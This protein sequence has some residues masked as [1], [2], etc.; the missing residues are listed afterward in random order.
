MKNFIFISP[1][2]PDVYYKFL[3]E[4]RNVGFNVL[5]IGDCPWHELSDNVK[6]NTSEYYYVHSLSNI[7]EMEEAVRYFKNKYGEIDYLES[8]NEFWL[9]QDAYLREKFNVLNGLR[10]ADMDV[11]KYKS[12]MKENF[13]KAGVKVARYIIPTNYEETI[14]FINSVGYPVFV[15]PDNGVGALDSYAIH[16]L[17]E[18][19]AFFARSD[20]HLFIMEE[21]IDGEIISFDGISDDDG[22]VLINFKEV[23]PVPI[24]DIANKDLDDLYYAS[25]DVDEEFREIGRKV[26]KAFNIKKRCFHIEFFKLKSHKEGLA[27]LGEIIALEVNMRP[28]GGNTPDLLSV[29]LN[30]SF[31]KCYAEAIMYNEIRED[32]NKDH[33]IALTASRKDRFSYV[34]SHEDV[35]NKW[36]HTIFD[37][38]RYNKEVALVMGNSYYYAKFDNVNEA[39]EFASFVHAKY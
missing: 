29:A 22:N 16:N 36:G 39:L 12:K 38:G 17:D 2:F 28:P 33:Y 35:L 24:A 3:I 30:G 7:N 15:K 37:H 19:N 1:N 26:V 8:N 23:F 34:N 6:A 27:T 18:L 31:Y 10:P 9:M 11:I 13:I 5:S 20:H 4:L 32:V 25:A 21:F 14:N